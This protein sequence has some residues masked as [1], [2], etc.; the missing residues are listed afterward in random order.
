MRYTYFLITILFSLLF[1][2]SCDKSEDYFKDQ[3]NAPKIMLKTPLLK[4]Y[5][6]VKQPVD[7]F[8][9]RNNCFELKTKVE[10]EEIL[11]VNVTVVNS[12]A[13][14]VK[15]MKKDDYHLLQPQQSGIVNYKIV[16]SDSFKATTELNGTIIVFDNLTPVPVIS[17]E[18]NQNKVTEL[19]RIISAENS[20]DKDYKYGGRIIQ[21]E[22]TI[23]NEAPVVSSKSKI[24]YIF[25]KKGSYLLSLRVKDNNNV[26]SD[27]VTKR[28]NI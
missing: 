27:I 3:N 8:K 19:E 1:L 5:I 20:Y 14:S 25:P 11:F 7:S 21:Y 26:W 22:Y 15:V 10:D 23:E 28:I 4:E 2:N 9:L 13:G 16:C 17:L 6:E 12:T 18:E 24:L